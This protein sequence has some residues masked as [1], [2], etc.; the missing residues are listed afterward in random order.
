MLEG[1]CDSSV[2]RLNFILCAGLLSALSTYLVVDLDWIKLLRL[3]SLLSKLGVKFV[4]STSLDY[5]FNS[6][7]SLPSHNSAATQELNHLSRFQR[8][9]SIVFTKNQIILL[10]PTTF[11]ATSFTLKFASCPTL[12]LKQAHHDHHVSPRD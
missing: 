7:L 2:P 4:C 1:K 10:K 6:F 3:S 12:L 11:S 9:V 5:L 8:R